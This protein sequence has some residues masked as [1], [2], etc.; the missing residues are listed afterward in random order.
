MVAAK[1]EPEKRELLFDRRYPK[2]TKVT[3]EYETDERDGKLI[4]RLWR[5]PK[6]R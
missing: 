4:V 6:K 1:V 2:G 3:A 5:E